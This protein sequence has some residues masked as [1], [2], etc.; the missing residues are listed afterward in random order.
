MVEYA[1]KRIKEHIGRFTKLY[2]QIKNNDID[3]E[4][5][6]DIYKKDKI[7]EEIDYMIYY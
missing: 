5:L 2:Y 1:H 6:D 4:F 3:K 7:F